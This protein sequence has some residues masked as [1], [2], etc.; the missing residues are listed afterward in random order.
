MSLREGNSRAPATC[1]WSVIATENVYEEVT[2]P[3]EAHN[4][5]DVLG[6]APAKVR[7][8]DEATDERCE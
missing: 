3:K 1:D 5:C 8:I 4:R 2:H 6:P 7:H